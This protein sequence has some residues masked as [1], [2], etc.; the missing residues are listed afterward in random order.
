[1]ETAAIL[2]MVG[3]LLLLGAVSN[4]LSS[5]ANMPILL[6]FLAIGMTA[7]HFGIIPADVANNGSPRTINMLGTV[8]MCFILYSGGLNT[9]FSSVREVLLP[10]SLLASFG[11]LITAVVMGLACYFIGRKIDSRV[12]LPWC[13][14]LGA[15]VSSTDAAAV[16]AV[17]RNRNT[18]LKG[19]IQPLL[20]VESGSNDPTAYLLTIILLDVVR[21]GSTPSF[22]S[23][24]LSLLG[25]VAWG[26]S[27]GALVGFAFGIIGQWIYTS[28]SRHRMLEYE[29]LYF[30]IGISVV[31]LTFG[32]TEKYLHANGLMAVYVCGITMGNIRFNF[33]KALTQFNDGISWLMQVSLFT[34]LGFMVVPRELVEPREL[35]SGLLLSALLLFAARPLAVWICMAGSRF[36]GRERVLISWVGL[37]G[38]APIMLA[39]FPLAANIP[40]AQDIFNKVF[41]MVL[42]SILVQGSTLMPLARRLGLACRSDER[43]RVPL[44]LEITEAGGDSEMFEFEVPPSATFAGATVA[45]LGLPA[46][47][48][49]LLVRRKGRF[50]S[51]R[52][53]SRIEAGDGMLIM[54]PGKVMREVGARFFPEADYRPARTLDEIRDSFP[55]LALENVSRMLRRHRRHGAAAER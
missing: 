2:A 17:L 16:M 34:V 41:F 40:Y 48:L 7:K 47:A 1:M 52:G 46:G 15:L 10:A 18:G 32:M 5:K 13:L 8:A 25:G 27:M 39:T 12:A 38:A 30:V 43:E 55:S 45:E 51:P 26:L 44:E 22:F 29:G 33:K 23:V 24:L 14:L 3:A 54:G 20:E 4:K 37:R 9:R 42:T 19:K 35:R 53:D 31:L 28:A 21:S 11:V 49:I 36:S 6:A 50:F